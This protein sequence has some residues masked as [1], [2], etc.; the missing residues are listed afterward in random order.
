[1]EPTSNGVTRRRVLTAA[2]LAAGVTALTVATGGAAHADQIYWRWCK[3]CG[4]LWFDGNGTNGRCPEGWFE[5]GHDRAGSGNYAL[6]YITDGGH[7]QS[8]WRWCASCQGLWFGGTGWFGD[9]PARDTLGHYPVG[10]YASSG[11]YVLEHEGDYDTWGFC[12]PQWRLCVKC[13]GLYFDGNTP[14]RSGVC[15]KDNQWHRT[16]LAANYYLRQV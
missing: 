1:M 13:L 12:Q 11:N 14:G 15:P 8:N 3:R 10:P 6:K 5:A 9:C 7:G 4:G 16:D 2:G